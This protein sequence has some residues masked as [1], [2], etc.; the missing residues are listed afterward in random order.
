MESKAVLKFARISPQKARL[1][2]NLIRGRDLED[3]LEV[4]TFTR[5]KTA[6]LIKKLIE[7]AVANAEQKVKGTDTV[8][9]VDNAYVKTIMVD[10]G[11]SLRRFRPRA[12]GRATPIKKL[13]SHITVVVG[14]RQD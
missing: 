4:L 9:D 14:T 10:Q 2:A 1:V 13:T 11:T 12:M 3:A 5:K 6:P 8:F 7:S